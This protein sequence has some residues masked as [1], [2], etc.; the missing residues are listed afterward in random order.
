MSLNTFFLTVKRFYGFVK[1][2]N[3]SISK[4]STSKW[5]EHIR[6]H[7]CYFS[8]QFDKNPQVCA[9]VEFL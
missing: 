4:E 6:V 3:L 2:P 7:I 1:R 9:D 8:Y 5:K